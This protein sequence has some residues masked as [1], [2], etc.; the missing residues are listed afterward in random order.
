MIEQGPTGAAS[1]TATASVITKPRAVLRARPED[2]R[3]EEIPAYEPTGEG[4]HAIIRFR[5]TGLTTPYAIRQ[6]AA[7]LGVDSREAGY[8]GL[9]D[10]HAITTQAASFPFPLDRDLERTLA[11]IALPGIEILSARRHPHKLKPGH[12][13]GNRFAITLRE[14]APTAAERIEAALAKVATEGVPNA[15]GPQRFGRDGANPD[16]ALAWLTGRA[17]GPRGRSEQRLIFSALQSHWFNQVLQRRIEAGSWNRV[18]AGDLA[19]KQDSGGLFL[20]PEDPEELADAVSRSER[21]AISP[22]GPMFGAKMRWPEGKVAEIEREV[23][24]SA[25]VEPALLGKFKRYGRGTRRAMR[26]QP[27]ET[28]CTAGNDLGYLTVSFVLPKGG[29]ATTVLSELCLPIEADRSSSPSVP[30]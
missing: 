3:V 6:L 22:T 10:R 4:T 24:Q 28:S 20:V 14:L 17:A 25:G 18:M 23:L 15:F 26:L 5:K 29:Y 2:F 1:A 11:D 21:G 12:L 19:K 8:A 16:R 27:T 7:A 9:K 13:R 30:P